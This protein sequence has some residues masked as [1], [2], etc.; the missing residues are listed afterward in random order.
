MAKLR[1]LMGK[2]VGGI[3]VM[4]IV[5]VLAVLALFA[6]SRMSADEPMPVEDESDGDGNPDDASVPV[7]VARDDGSSVLTGDGTVFTPESNDTWRVRAA[8]WLMANRKVS[9]P[10]AQRIV[11]NYL[12]G[13]TASVTDGQHRDAVINALGLPPVLP[14]APQATVTPSVTPKF[15][16]ARQ[17]KYT[18]KRGDTIASIAQKNHITIAQLISLNTVLKGFKGSHRPAVGRVLT[19]WK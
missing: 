1:E 19:V 6:A 9:A 15:D 13:E 4:A 7:F 3:P 10:E 12:T 8:A 2:R 16:P 5:L 14:D 11:D 18:V 17:K